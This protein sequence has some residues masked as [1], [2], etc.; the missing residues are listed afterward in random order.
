[1]GDGRD[2]P[3]CTHSR[4]RVAAEGTAEVEEEEARQ[5]RGEVDVLRA[6]HAQ[7]SADLEALCAQVTRFFRGF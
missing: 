2:S 1:M 7:I 4:P 6:E 3:G 5:L